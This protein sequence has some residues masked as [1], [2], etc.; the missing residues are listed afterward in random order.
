MK[1][2]GKDFIRRVLLPPHGYIAW[3]YSTGSNGQESTIPNKGTA[4]MEYAAQGLITDG[5]GY[6]RFDNSTA[7]NIGSNDFDITVCG[8]FTQPTTAITAYFGRDNTT[9]RGLLI[10]MHPNATLFNQK[11]LFNIP[12]SSSSIVQ[13]KPV[14][15]IP[16]GYGKLRYIKSGT[17]LT[18]YYNDSEISWEFNSGS[19]IPATVYDNTLNYAMFV[20]YSSGTPVVHTPRHLSYVKFSIAGTTKFET[21]FSEGSGSN[22]DC[23]ANT[24]NTITLVGGITADMWNTFLVGGGSWAIDK[25]YKLSTGVRVPSLLD[26]SGPVGGGSFTHVGGKLLNNDV[27]LIVCTDPDHQPPTIADS[28]TMSGATVYAQFNGQYDRDGDLNGL[29][30]YTHTTN[31]DLYLALDYD[32]YNV[33]D[34]VIGFFDVNT[35]DT[36]FYIE[37]SSSKE[38]P[39]PD[40]LFVDDDTYFESLLITPTINNDPSNVLTGGLNK[41]DIDALNIN[42]SELRSAIDTSGYMI[43]VILYDDAPTGDALT[44][45]N[46]YL[47]YLE[48]L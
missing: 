6:V 12:T 44:K 38:Y 35:V 42:T 27:E 29:P 9:D 36:A 39:Y 41:P 10:F 46:N 1:K 2:R 13:I 28:Y 16:A 48:T 33:F 32:N 3:M 45:L 18:M 25:G 24:G 31:S 7:W 4:S 15:E 34:N 40:D 11:P 22:I 21:Y 43:E 37:Q 30:K 5:T 8:D 19:S 23:I 47:A 26:G 17:S 20:Q 14:N